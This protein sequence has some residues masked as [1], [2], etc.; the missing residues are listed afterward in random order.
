MNDKIVKVK[1]NFIQNIEDKTKKGWF[2]VE[3]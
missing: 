1:I 3:I 2:S